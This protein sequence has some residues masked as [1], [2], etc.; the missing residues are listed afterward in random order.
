[1]T[2]TKAP[3]P[4]LPTPPLS[5]NLEREREREHTKRGKKKYKPKNKNKK[6]EPTTCNGQHTTHRER[7]RSVE[8]R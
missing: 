3:P 4:R 2:E 1:V 7:E 5:E 8:K 6:A